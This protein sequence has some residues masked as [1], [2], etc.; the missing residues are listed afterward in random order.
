MPFHQTYSIMFAHYRV[1]LMER[2]YASRPDAR[3]VP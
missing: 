3:T 2:L 1:S